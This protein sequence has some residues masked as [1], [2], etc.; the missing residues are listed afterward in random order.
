MSRL[1]FTPAFALA[2]LV[3][4]C[5]ENTAPG[6][7]REAAL[8]PP[9]PPAD[10]ADAPTA[11]EGVATDLLIPQ[12]M[13]NADVRNAPEV[14]ERCVFR[15]TRVG[16]PIFLYGS[17]G[18]VKLNGKLVSL[19]TA[20]ESGP[21]ADVRR[22]AAGPVA[23]TV[24]PL[25]G[26]VSNGGPFAAEL[27]LQLED[28][29]HELGYHGYAECDGSARAQGRPAGLPPTASADVESGAVSASDGGGV[30]CGAVER[31]AGVLRVSG[32]VRL[33]PTA[34]WA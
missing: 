4:A 21:R 23:V 16:L 8:S 2:L 27:V 20:D 6:N 5:T 15:F 33:R 9:E 22:Y 12:A 32:I 7:D 26:P 14:G 31:P 29:S 1:R 30:A 24:R 17:A 10:I 18:V 11:T 13:T 34:A 25:D 3:G 28:A 19:P